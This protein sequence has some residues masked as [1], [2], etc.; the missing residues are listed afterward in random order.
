LRGFELLRLLASIKLPKQL[1]IFAKTFISFT[2]YILPYFFILLCLLFMITLISMNLFRKEIYV[3]P[4][5]L[6]KPDLHEY[7]AYFVTSMQVLLVSDWQKVLNRCSYAYGSHTGLYFIFCTIILKYFLENLMLA[8]FVYIYS[9]VHSK[10]AKEDA[11]RIFLTF[12]KTNVEKKKLLGHS[13]FKNHILNLG[14][15]SSAAAPQQRE[16]AI[17]EPISNKNSPIS[18]NKSSVRPIPK[19]NNNSKITGVRYVSKALKF[20]KGA[21]KKSS[22]LSS[23][24][25][26]RTGS[27]SIAAR[28]SK[29]GNI[30]SKGKRMTILSKDDTNLLFSPRLGENT[31]GLEGPGLPLEFNAEDSPQIP[32]RS[33]ARRRSRIA[34]GGNEDENKGEPTPVVRFGHYNPPLPPLKLPNPDDQP[35]RYSTMQP[36]SDLPSVEESPAIGFKL[37]KPNLPPID[38]PIIAEDSQPAQATLETEAN[39]PL[40]TNAENKDDSKGEGSPTPQS[41]D[42]GNRPFFNLFRFNTQGANKTNQ[43]APSGFRRNA[44]Q[45]QIHHRIDARLPSIHNRL[46][47]VG[48]GSF[49]LSMSTMRHSSWTQIFTRKGYWRLSF[50]FSIADVAIKIFVTETFICTDRTNLLTLVAVVEWIINVFFFL[51]LV[52]GIGI[53][54]YNSRQAIKQRIVPRISLDYFEVVLLVAGIIHTSLLRSFCTESALSN[55]A[56]LVSIFNFYRV[57]RRSLTYKR[58]SWIIIRSINH[59]FLGLV[60]FFSILMIFAISSYSM[61]KGYTT[62]CDLPTFENITKEKVG[63]T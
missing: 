7:L 3:S 26:L 29:Q 37:I 24:L 6:E 14:N 46:A 18:P 31:L 9:D 60:V 13:I 58:Y 43:V 28:A 53:N 12:E 56:Y 23:T 35:K 40:M 36:H 62:S 39:E 19:P 55:A 63:S 15:E 8:F 45:K 1:K 51:E 27:I 52:F 2:A 22:N 42:R 4:Y 33:I 21:R 50:L 59:V 16:K 54:R 10:Y 48:S 17:Q 34:P 47:G 44:S 30:F 20:F 57:I 61:F 49:L 11:S 41:P 5:L 32:E 25:R 38:L